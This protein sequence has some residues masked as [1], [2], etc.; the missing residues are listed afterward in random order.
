MPGKDNATPVGTF[1]QVIVTGVLPVA[2]LGEAEQIIGG[3]LLKTNGGTG[4][5]ALAAAGEPSAAVTVTGG[6]LPKPAAVPVQ[7]TVPKP[8]PVKGLGI[9]VEPGIEIIIPL[10]TFVQ[11]VVTTVLPEAAIGDAV[12]IGAEINVKG[13]GGKIGKVTAAAGEPVCAVTVIEGLL[14]KPAAVP[15]QVTVPDTA[16][17]KGLGAQVE[18]GTAMIIPSGTSMQVV[19]TTVLPKAAAGETEQ[20]GTKVNG[21]GGKSGKAPAAAGEPG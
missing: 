10:V 20:V 5:R 14:P 12:Q 21:N 3:K 1:E 17:V 9:Q 11:V 8:E 19:V 2:E 6:L 16:P 7:V 4:G 18:P 15:V 13:S